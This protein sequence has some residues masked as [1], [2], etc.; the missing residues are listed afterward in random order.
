MFRILIIMI[1]GIWIYAHSSETRDKM[2]LEYVKKDTLSNFKN[3]KD[4]RCGFF[5]INNKLYLYDYDTNESKGYFVF[6]KGD[7]II[8][9]DDCVSSDFFSKIKNKK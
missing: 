2:I 5:T 3:G 4:I 7:E 8:D 9:I 6:K 1:M